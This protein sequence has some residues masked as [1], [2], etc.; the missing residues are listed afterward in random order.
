MSKRQSVGVFTLGVVVGAGVLA[1]AGAGERSGDDQV[2]RVWSERGYF[3][4]AWSDG[5]VDWARVSPAESAKLMTSDKAFRGWNW[6]PLEF[7]K[8]VP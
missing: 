4:R 3:Y 7:T 1:L 6:R 5:R 8:L 2:V